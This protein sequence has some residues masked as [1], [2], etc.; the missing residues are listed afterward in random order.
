MPKT[1]IISQS[2][3]IED[4]ITFL[5]PAQPEDLIILST[6]MDSNPGSLQ[7]KSLLRDSVQF[8]I[9]YPVIATLAKIAL[10]GVLSDNGLWS[11]L[12]YQTFLTWKRLLK[13]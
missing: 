11:S 13:R 10:T 2:V 4:R 12:L 9:E 1:K 5:I 6:H 7:A 3:W 8:I